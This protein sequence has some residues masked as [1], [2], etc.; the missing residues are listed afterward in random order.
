MLV[1]YIL[2]GGEHPFGK[3]VVCEYNIL[4]GVSNLEHVQDAVAKDLIER[5][6]NKDPNKRPTVEECLAHPFFW[7]DRRYQKLYYTYS[8]YSSIHLFNVRAITNTAHI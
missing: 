2:S 1:Y 4:K 6:I 5:M 7:T 8:I 3:T